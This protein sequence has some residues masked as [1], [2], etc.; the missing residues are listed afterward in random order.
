MSSWCDL[1]DCR[2]EAV[3]F[4]AYESLLAGVPGLEEALIAGSPSE[5]QRIA[6]LVNSQL[7]EMLSGH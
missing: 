7:L 6:D 5:I 3:E 1:L 4:S 2:R